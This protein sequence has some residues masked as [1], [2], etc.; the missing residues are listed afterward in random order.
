[1]CIV[2]SV[3]VHASSPSTSFNLAEHSDEDSID[4]TGDDY[5][6]MELF[7]LNCLHKV[8]LYPEVSNSSFCKNLVCWEF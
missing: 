3:E 8:L 1:M 2:Y 5:G 6:N 4:D 7:L